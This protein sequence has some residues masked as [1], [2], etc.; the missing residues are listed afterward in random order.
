ME[1]YGFLH[2]V[3]KPQLIQAVI[4]LQ[5]SKVIVWMDTG[6]LVGIVVGV[7]I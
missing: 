7:V 1:S 3:A 5:G 6:L 2:V 4:S